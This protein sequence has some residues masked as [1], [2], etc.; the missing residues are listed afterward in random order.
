L[1]GAQRGAGGEAELAVAAKVDGEPIC[2]REVERNAAQAL[3]GRQATPQALKILHAQAL[4]QLID[5][6]LIVRRL[7]RG[8]LGASGQD[9][10]L[11][12]ERLQ[13]R[14]QRQG[15]TLADHLEKARMSEAELRRELAWRLS[16][17]RYLDQYLTDENLQ[18]YFDQHRRELDGTQVRVA[19]ILLKPEPLGGDEALDRALERGKQI[20]EKIVSGE[21]EF[22]E[23]ARRYSD[24]PT[25]PEGGEVGFISRHEPMSETFSRAAFALAPGRISEPVVSSFGVHLIRCHEV[26]P[27]DKR[28]TDVRQELET[29]V[30]NY[31]FQWLAERERPE[32]QIEF[33]GRCPYFRPGTKELADEDRH[34]EPQPP[35]R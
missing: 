8:E 24:A 18:R 9:V 19:H 26:K 25:A 17:R 15:R 11:A 6:R 29:A 7:Q 35:S 10:D 20:R 31:L 34:A 1:R 14:L 32:A 28:W 21:L 30:A 16:W 3:G 12:I 23:A 33:T 2:V 13:K 27:G 22:G 4:Q 5:R